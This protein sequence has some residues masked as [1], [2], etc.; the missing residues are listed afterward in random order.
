MKQR[1][2]LAQED[3]ATLLFAALVLMAL[4]L[5]SAWHDSRPV[6]P[7]VPKGTTQQR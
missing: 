5:F 2:N 4:F 6:L 1:R 3:W 7:P